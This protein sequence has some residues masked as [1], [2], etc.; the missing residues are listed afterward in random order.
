MHIC[1][2]N[3]GHHCFRYWLVA[4]SVP[5]HYINQYWNIV[6]CTLRK[7]LQVNF[8]KNSYIFIQENAF[9]NVVWKKAGILSQPQY[10]KASVCQM[11]L[12]LLPPPIPSPYPSRFSPLPSQHTAGD[13]SNRTL[14]SHV[15]NQ[16]CKAEMSKMTSEGRTKVNKT[17]CPY[18]GVIC[19][20]HHLREFNREILYIIC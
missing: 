14:P 17:V 13:R 3:L 12:S 1:I 10:V 15:H 9:E 4:W 6:N 5:S 20:T 19:T 7:K 8:Y 18:P 11:M 2:D 16:L